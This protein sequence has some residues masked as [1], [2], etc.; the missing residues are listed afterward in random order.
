V[1]EGVRIGRIAGVETR[2]DWTTLL[3]FG[4]IT[5]NLHAVWLPAADPSRPGGVIVSWAVAVLGA[6]VFY[7]CLLA[8]ELSHAVVAQHHGIEVERI[9]LWLFGG[10]A[11]M[12]RE[13]RQARQELTIAVAGPATSVVLG[14][15][16]LTAAVAERALG[17]PEVIRALTVWLGVVNIVLGVFNLLPAFPLDGG[18][19]LRAVVWS[20]TGDRGRATRVAVSSGRGFSFL[21]M[22]LGGLEV[23]AGGGVGG[24]WLVF[25]GWFILVAGRSEGAA[26]GLDRIGG[27]TV[28]QVMTPDPV[29]V[30]G[31][32][33]VATFAEGL[34]TQRHSAFP[35]FDPEGRPVGLVDL[36]RVRAL[37]RSRWDNT[38]D[39]VRTLFGRLGRR[40]QRRALVLDDRRRLV[41]IVSATDLARLIDR[42]EILD[43]DRVG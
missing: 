31:R 14:A 36:H 33:S 23:L 9:T 32:M 3:I 11:Q 37:P 19:V 30:D 2:V 12:Q 42:A 41:G 10:V 5:W 24:I 40:D 21:L 16:F 13:P 27:L 18:R 35:V 17:A 20:V 25:I 1:N 22:G 34:W 26:A 38:T 28:A 29:G 4:L 43:T 7:A 15:A 8:H 39:L 6:A